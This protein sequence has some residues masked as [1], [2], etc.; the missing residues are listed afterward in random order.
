MENIKRFP[1]RTNEILIIKTKFLELR[2]ELGQL[3][4]RARWKWG[5]VVQ[6]HMT[7]N[8]AFVI[9]SFW[10]F[11]DNTVGAMYNLVFS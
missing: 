2:P 7:S 3:V 4:A 10:V 9:V 1:H 8:V 6:G 11:E 5:R